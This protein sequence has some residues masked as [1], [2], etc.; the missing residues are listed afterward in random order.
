M[1]DVKFNVAY[2]ADLLIFGID[3]RQNAN[4]R[5]LP[6]KFFSI[7]LVKRG[8]EPFMNKWC[9]PGGFIGS[10]ETSKNASSRVLKKETGLTDVYMQ[11]LKVND[12]VDRDPRGRVVSVSYMALID[13]TLL[14]SDLNDDASWFDIDVIEDGE[15]YLINLTNGEDNINFEVKRNVIDLKSEEFSYDVVKKSDLAFDHEKLIIEGIMALRDKVNKTDIVFNLMPQEFTI[16]ELKQVYELILN[17]KLVNSAFR[18]T[19]ADKVLLLDKMVQTGGHRPS[20]LCKYN[21]KREK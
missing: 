15:N 8:K 10:D 3:S 7:L 20:V 11:Q 2:T 18:R 12:S 9:L 13:R 1:M 19:I 17:K 16:G 6:K 14:T 5:S 21:E 4:T